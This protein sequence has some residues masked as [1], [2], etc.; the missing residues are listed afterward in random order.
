MRERIRSC[1]VIATDETWAVSDHAPIATE[2][3]A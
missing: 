2:I 1:T 3:D